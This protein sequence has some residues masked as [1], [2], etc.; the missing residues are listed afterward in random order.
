M[1]YSNLSNTGCLTLK[2]WSAA[3]SSCRATY[4]GSLAA[5]S[6]EPENNYI[7]LQLI[8]YYS[9]VNPAEQVRVWM[10]L[11]EYLNYTTGI[12]YWR[13]TNEE[14]YTFADWSQGEPYLDPYVAFTGNILAGRFFHWAVFE[15]RSAWPYV[16]EHKL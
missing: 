15:G 3:D 2:D 12:P 4:G 11:Y 6:T 16:C 8:E 13:F 14:P 10:G 9:V 1:K 5:P 7:R